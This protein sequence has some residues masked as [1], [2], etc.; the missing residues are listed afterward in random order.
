MKNLGALTRN[1][2][3]SL[4]ILT[5]DEAGEP[6]NIDRPVIAKINKLN[7]DGLEEVDSVT[8]KAVKDYHG[9]EYVLPS[10]LDNGRYEILY[11]VVAEG[12][13]FYQKEYFTLIEEPPVIGLNESEEDYADRAEY[14]LPP[15]FQ[16]PA[17]LKV[18]G[19][20]VTIIPHDELKPN[21]NYRIVVTKN[22]QSQN[23]ENLDDDYEVHFT[24]EYMP[25]YA[26]PL[27]IR[28]IVRDV[29]QYFELQDIYEA[30]RNAGQKAHQLLRMS[31]NPNQSDF[32]LIGED[33]DTYFPATK[34]VV[35]QAANQLLNQLIIKLMYAVDEESGNPFIR[36]DSGI[37]YALGDF[38]VKKSDE[39]SETTTSGEPPELVTIKQL[40]E[41]NEEE[42]KFWQD[43]LLGRNARGYASPTSVTSRGGVVSPESRDI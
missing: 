18:E 14:I 20:V 21:H 15:E 36:D 33:D 26:T 25:L 41:H 40:I 22:V 39:K 13:T 3:I 5:K 12:E 19:H 2:K 6:L 42:I 16:V 43:A 24:T 28:S 29:F 10:E 32:E 31:A 8:L 9:G 37:S 4:G 7:A 27:E 38:Q 34:F 23:Q 1:T 35:H 30:I 17:E 11:E